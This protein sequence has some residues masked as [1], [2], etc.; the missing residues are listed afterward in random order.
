MDKENNS[1]EIEKPTP[2]KITD[3]E[4]ILDFQKI[5]DKIAQNGDGKFHAKLKSKYSP[6]ELCGCLRNAWYSRIFPVPYDAESYRAFLFGNMVHEMFQKNLDYPDRYK[7]FKDTELLDRVSFVESEKGF[8]YLLPFEKTEGRRVI[9]SG[10]LD[11]IIFLKGAEKPIIVD[12]KTTKAIKYNLTEPKDAHISQVNFYLGCTLGD[13]GIIVYIDK[14]TFQIVQHTIHYSYDRFQ[15]M[16]DFAVDLDNAIE[17]KKC[18]KIDKSEMAKEGYCS[19]CKYAKEC[20]V[21]ED[22]GGKKWLSL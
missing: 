14:G 12:Y 22:K 9:I 2:L 8:H 17:K 21:E 20:K 6:T 10:R 15:K 4:R 11:S 5:L 16:I 1:K 3:V 19:Y 18:P 13:H 7:M